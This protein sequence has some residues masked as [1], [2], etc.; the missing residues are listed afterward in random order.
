MFFTSQQ[1]CPKQSA[2]SHS[3]LPS[4]TLCSRSGFFQSHSDPNSRVRRGSSSRCCVKT[5]FA[6]ALQE[7]E[8]NQISTKTIFLLTISL[9]ATH[10]LQ[11]SFCLLFTSNNHCKTLQPD[12]KTR[13]VATLQANACLKTFLM[14]ALRMTDACGRQLNHIIEAKRPSLRFAWSSH[15]ITT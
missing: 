6:L 8:A 1:H 11:L 9:I 4:R 5:F 7:I 14:P 2:A 10:L 13:Q 3:S 15:Y 12:P